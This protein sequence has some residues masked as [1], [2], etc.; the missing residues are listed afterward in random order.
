[1]LVYLPFECQSTVRA[2]L[3]PITHF[4]FY[5]Y[6]PGAVSRDDANLH[7]RPTSLDGFRRDLHDCSAV[8]SNAGFELSSECLAL[9]K[10]ILVKPQ[11][12]QMEQASNALALHTLGYG[13][14]LDELDSD[15]ITRWLIDKRSAPKINFP[16]VA[17]ALVDWLQRGQVGPDSL[18]GL[19]DRLWEQVQVDLSEAA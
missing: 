17:G 11:G 18:Q 4:D 19:S 3:A 13:H 6:A 2:A 15:R 12:R 5:M 7:T 10:R 9:G 16:D 1:M 8:I 14:V